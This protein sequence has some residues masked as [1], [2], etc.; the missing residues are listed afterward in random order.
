M[1][2]ALAVRF[3]YLPGV[4]VND[5]FELTWADTPG[6]GMDWSCWS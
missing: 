1:G 6:Q 5:A 3:L 4:R 2:A